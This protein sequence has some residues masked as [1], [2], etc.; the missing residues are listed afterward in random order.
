MEP[1]SLSDL[2]NTLDKPELNKPKKPLI[3]QI[4]DSENLFQILELFDFC[5]DQKKADTL[6]RQPKNIESTFKSKPI[7]S[8]KNIN[9]EQEAMKSLSFSALLDAL[10]EQKFPKEQLY[11]IEISAI[12]NTFTSAQVAQLLEKF[13]FPRYKLKALKILRD[14]I[15]DPENHFLLL[16]VFK[17]GLN[18]K[19]ASALLKYEENE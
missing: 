7:A 13:H 6:L 12:R 1:L 9:L 2:L 17:H 18:K 5:S 16:K 15:I 14:Q 3:Q 4:S 10:G 11:F 19:K 8:S